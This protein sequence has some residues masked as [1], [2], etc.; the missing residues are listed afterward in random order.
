[1]EL[2][3]RQDPPTD[4]ADGVLL[5]GHLSGPGDDPVVIE[6]V[7]VDPE[8]SWRD[9]G[10]RPAL[11][12]LLPVAMRTGGILHID[13]MVDRGTLAGLAAWQE[14]MVAW[15]PGTLH[16][17][18]LRADEVVEPRTPVRSGT[19]RSAFSGGVDSCATV[20]A[21]GPR[22]EPR[23]GPTV[24][25]GV[26]VHGMDIPVED[27]ATFDGA[28]ARARSVLAGLD[29]ELITVRTDV[30]RLEARFG[31]DWQTFTHGIWL[32]AAL[33]CV[34]HG[35][36]ELVIP[37]TY[38]YP[39]LRLPWASNPITDPMLGSSITAVRHDGAGL[40]KLDKVATL[41]G[42]RSVEAGLRVCWE[43]EHLDRNCGRCFKCVSTQAC[44]WVLGVERPGAF[45]P[46]ASPADLTR[47]AW[48]DTY[49]QA[50]ARRL[51]D[52]ARA[53]GREDVVVAVEQV[54]R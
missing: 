30:R 33:A 22:A 42:H 34:E 7:V 15:H 10:L 54:I 21:H 31:L 40:D 35:V 26:L 48:N 36:D 43:G 17:V 18:E 16:P 46:A 25:A 28:A 1:M 8:P 45:D 2:V 29:V 41:V 6:H 19:A 39:Q 37:S 32:V 9:P 11:L 3:V 49:K 5:R 27:A 38:P 20:V 23:L 47:V 51:R 52:A 13:G 12:G 4:A 24:R 14:A 44:F 50:L 53:A